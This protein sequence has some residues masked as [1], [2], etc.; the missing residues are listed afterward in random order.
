MGRIS[1]KMRVE[2]YLDAVQAE[3]GARSPDAVRSIELDAL[4]D[5]GA[6]M[7]ALPRSVIQR[8][9]LRG[10]TERTIRTACGPVPARTF[11]G[12]RVTV[13]ERSGIFDA[14]ELPDDCPALLGQIP[15]EQLD[16]VADPANRR[17]TANPEHHGKWMLDAFSLPAH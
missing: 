5:T 4:V 15:L 14:V 10:G 6:T 3:D 16:F 2:N 9:G 1:V 7:L 13:M 12:A 17:L 11:H 8:L